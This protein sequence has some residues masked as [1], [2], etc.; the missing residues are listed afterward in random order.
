MSKFTTILWDLD[1]TILDFNRSQRYALTYSFEKLG[2]Y[3][4]DE[5]IALYSDINDSYWK[6]LE[7]GEISKEEVHSGR[8]RTLF[9][10]LNI[11][12]ISAEE[13]AIIYQE[14][15]GSV[16]FFQDE[17]DQLIMR[18]KEQGFGQY[19]L[20]NGFLKTQANKIRISGLDKLVDDSFPSEEIG[21]PKPRKEYF[22]ACFARM[23]AITREECILVGDS[24]TSDMQGGI[25]AGIAVCWYNPE[26]RPN[27]LNLAI[28]YEI[29]D[30]HE[31]TFVLQ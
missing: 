26:G 2:L 21:Y 7:K 22:D 27:D 9:E 29:R 24:L 31:L 17:A 4:N 28:D 12:G 15:L 3:I 30:L 8:F 10:K 14:A 13:I 18:F 6:R 23:G 16:Y 20:T 1:Q 11:T 19:I 5:I 25:G